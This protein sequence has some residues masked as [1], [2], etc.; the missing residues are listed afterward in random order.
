MLL[1]ELVDEQCLTPWSAKTEVDFTD[2]DVLFL[3]KTSKHFSCF[4]QA[5]PLH[6]VFL[7]MNIKFQS[8]YQSNKCKKTAIYDHQKSSYL[9]CWLKTQSC[10]KK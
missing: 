5:L 8:L 1:Q 2:M 7:I 10:W 3:I 9:E 4:C 6:S